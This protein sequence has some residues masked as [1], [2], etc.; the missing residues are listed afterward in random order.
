MVLIISTLAVVALAMSMSG[1]QNCDHR[2]EI[3]GSIVRLQI[4]L[5]WPMARI[6]RLIGKRSGGGDPNAIVGRPVFADAL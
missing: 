4:H 5:L 3:I 1:L 2:R 6:R